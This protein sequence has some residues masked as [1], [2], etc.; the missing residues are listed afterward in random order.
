PLLFHGVSVGV[1]GW[2]SVQTSSYHDA[3]DENIAD[4]MALSKAY[5]KIEQEGMGKV[6][7]GRQD[8]DFNWLTDYIDGVTAEVTVIDNLVLSM[9]WA[10]SN[11]V[12]DIDEISERFTKINGH[13]GVYML[14]AK[15]TPVEILELN[16]YL[17]YGNDLLDAYGMKATL[18]LEPSDAVKTTTMAHYVTVNSDVADVEDG[19]FAQF[20]QGVEL[21]GVALAAGYMRTHDDGMG[22]LNELGDQSPFE[23]GNHVFDPEAKTPYVSASYEIEGVTLSALYGQ[24]KYY[25]GDADKKFKEKELDVSVS[26]EIIKNLEAS[27][28]YVNVDNDQKDESYNAYKAHISYNF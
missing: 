2:G 17:Y 11:A 27:L 28:M 18:S 8:V 19:S 26:Y 13:D 9:A 21:F 10:Q 4:R 6:V 5:L 12:I 7:L 20:E 15:Y 24:T 14:D 1:A 22:G 25:D 23:E 3:Y 16:P